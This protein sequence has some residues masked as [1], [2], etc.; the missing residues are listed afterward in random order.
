M[1]LGQEFSLEAA[2]KLVVAALSP[3]SILHHPSATVG[4]W[5][6]IGVVW[7]GRGGGV[8][9]IRTPVRPNFNSAEFCTWVVLNYSS[10]VVLG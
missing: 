2:G 9:V 1:A 10:Y 6:V 4:C 8:V 7:V 5:M 3:G